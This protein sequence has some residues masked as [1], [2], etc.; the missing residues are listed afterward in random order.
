MA[1]MQDYGGNNMKNNKNMILLLWP[2]IWAKQSFLQ[3]IKFV[4]FLFFTIITTLMVV[5]VPLLLKQVIIALESGNSNL[6]F[7]PIGIVIL[8]GLSWMLTKVIDRL[9]HQSAFPMISN[10]IHQLCLDLF[11]HLQYLSMRFHHDKKSGRVFNIMSRS[12]NAIAAFTQAIAQELLP[13]FLQIVLATLLLTYH[14][15]LKYG[16]V[17]LL[18][19]ILYL[20]LSIKT[21]GMIVKRRQEQNE[22]DGEAHAFIVDSLL[23]AET[24]KYFGTEKNELAQARKLLV[25]KQEADILSLMSDAK[26]HLIQNTII[27][28]ALVTLTIVSGFAVFNHELHVSDFVMI[29]SFILMFMSPLSSLGHRYRQAK[30]QLAHLESA[31]ALLNEPIEVTDS[32]QAA[33]LRFE[34]GHIEFENVSFGYKPDRMILKNVSFAVKPGTTTAIV[35]AS[36]SGKSTISKLLL[37]LYDTSSGSIKIDHQNIKDITRA[38]LC[39]TIGIVPQDTVM[40]NDT[41]AHNIAYSLENHSDVNFDAILRAVNLKEFVDSLQ[42]GIGTMIGERGLKLSGGER[43]RLALA[44]LLA[45]KAKIMVF[46]EATSALDLENERKIQKCLKDVSKGMTTIIIAH[47]LSTIKHADNIIVLDDGQIAEQGTHQELLDKNGIYA[48]LLHMQ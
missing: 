39:H 19:C 6:G 42:G 18:M 8:Y 22:T 15:G 35:G 4:V 48:A 1:T 24:V 14:Y 11:A 12:R 31:F 32:A 21:A 3:K 10:I 26:V 2:Y 43:Q 13:L 36:G 27:G 46:D 20:V 29:N 40:F 16:A 28:A 38:S 41:I 5:S 44:R 33:P 25:Q 17:L 9:R 47:R 37:R 45:R 34:A 30:S 7:T 23:N